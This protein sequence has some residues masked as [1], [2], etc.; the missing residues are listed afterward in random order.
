MTPLTTPGTPQSQI[1]RTT[2]S[3]VLIKAVKSES[4][5]KK[6]EGK[7]FTLRD[8]D[9]SKVRTCCHLKTLIR[10]Q[11]QEDIHTGDFDVGYIQNN[12]VVTLRSPE[13]IQ[14]VWSSLSRGTK[15]TLWCNG[16]RGTSSKSSRKR[17][18]QRGDDS[19]EDDSG[20]ECSSKSRKK[21]KDEEKDQQVHRLIEDP[22][23]THQDTYTTMQYR[24]WSEMI[25]GGLHK[26]TDTAPSNPLFL[27]AGGNYPKKKPISGGDTLTQAVADIASAIVKSR[28]APSP[29]SMVHSPAKI[30]DSRSKCYRQLSELKSLFESGLLSDEEYQVE[31][32]AIMNTLKKFTC[33]NVEGQDPVGQCN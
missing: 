3:K 7:T 10:A 19:E 24:I 8:I 25:I 23:S 14:E 1:P 5:G 20:A 17:K 9:P 21:T 4:S 27:R 12:S 13:D 33:Y 26:S 6:A 11:L 18:Q 15:V 2:I 28:P 16:L 29:N 22:K 31:R 32:E 30:I